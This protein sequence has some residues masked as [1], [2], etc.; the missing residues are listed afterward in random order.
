MLK[1]R[2]I[3]V[4]IMIA[5]LFVINLASLFVIPYSHQVIE[6][7]SRQ[8][9]VDHRSHN[10]CTFS[11]GIISQGFIWF[12]E[13]HAEF[14]TALAT[15]FIALFTFTL[16]QSTDKLWA[17]GKSQR[18]IAT[19]TL[20]AAHRPWIKAQVMD[21]SIYVPPSAPTLMMNLEINFQNIGQSPARRVRLYAELLNRP[22]GQPD[23]ASAQAEICERHRA[24]KIEKGFLLFPHDDRTE[25]TSQASLPEQMLGQMPMSVGGLT[26]VICIAYDSGLTDGPPHMTSFVLSAR[27]TKGNLDLT[28]GARLQMFELKLERH[29]PREIAD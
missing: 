2:L 8:Q 3:A 25:T 18:A 4:A 7:G 23:A 16:W 11:D 26:A 29:F 17:E 27:P 6:C 22:D 1:V 13:R 12:Y 19:Q 10:L 5:A 24:D 21:V 15:L 9:A 20:I 28:V 14:W